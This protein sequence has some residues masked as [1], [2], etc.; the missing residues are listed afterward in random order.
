MRSF[1]AAW[2]KSAL[3]NVDGTVGDVTQSELQTLERLG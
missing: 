2:V 1:M 3:H